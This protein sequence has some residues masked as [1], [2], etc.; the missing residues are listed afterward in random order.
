MPRGRKP[1]IANASRLSKALKLKAK[2]VKVAQPAEPVV[3]AADNTE[4]VEVLKAIAR[5]QQDMTIIIGRIAEA[6]EARPVEKAPRK[7]RAEATP[8]TPAPVAVPEKKAPV[9]TNFAIDLAKAKAEKAAKETA[10][11]PKAEPM[12]PFTAM[13]A[14]AIALCEADTANGRARLTAI[15]NTVAG[16]GNLTGVADEKRAEVTAAL[17]KEVAGG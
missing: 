17:Q 10:A 12:D 4:V 5:N 9:V 8:E 7:P 1:S 14:A 6:L 15:L 2:P 3:E 11:A 13:R 16:V